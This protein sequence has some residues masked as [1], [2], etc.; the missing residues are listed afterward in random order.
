MTVHSSEIILENRTE[1]TQ[2]F[3]DFFTFVLLHVRMLAMCVTDDIPKIIEQEAY[4]KI[5]HD[6]MRSLDAEFPGTS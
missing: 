4:A 2:A 5:Q 1:N 6:D 3:V